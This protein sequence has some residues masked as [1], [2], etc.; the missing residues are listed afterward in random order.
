[1]GITSCMAEEKQ[2]VKCTLL[3]IFA[4]L[5]LANA[6]HSKKPTVVQQGS[7]VL[8]DSLLLKSSNGWDAEV[9]WHDAGNRRCWPEAESQQLA[10]LR[11]GAYSVMWPDDWPAWSASR[12]SD[13]NVECCKKKCRNRLAMGCRAISVWIGGKRCD[14]FGGVAV[15]TVNTQCSANRYG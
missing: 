4:A 1:M 7:A 12:F 13:C 5:V 14:T 6:V 10:T 8:N 11:N 15:G 2:P 3:L 9:D